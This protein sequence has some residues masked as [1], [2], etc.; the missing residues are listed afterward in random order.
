MRN[1]I[2][3]NVN[4]ISS[5]VEL[6]SRS[7]SATGTSDFIRRILVFSEGGKT[8]TQVAQRGSEWPIPGN[9]QSQV[10]QGSEQLTL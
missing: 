9:I 5:T 2:E 1:K 6:Q 10:G 3:K 7:E 8:L 4:F